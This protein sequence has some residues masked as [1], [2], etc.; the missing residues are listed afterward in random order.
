[1]SKIVSNKLTGTVFPAL[2]CCWPVAS[3]STRVAVVVTPSARIDDLVTVLMSQVA[4]A[5]STLDYVR[6]S[7]KI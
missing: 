2:L 1:M 5:T 6:P 3:D 4:L 7:R